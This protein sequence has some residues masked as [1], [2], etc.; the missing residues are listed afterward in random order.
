MQKDEAFNPSKAWIEYINRALGVWVGLLSLALCIHAARHTRKEHGRAFVYLLLSLFLIV[1]QG[2]LGAVVVITHLLPVLV[3]L[4]M[5]LPFLILTT[6]LSA[7]YAL[8]ERPPT[9]PLPLHKRFQ[10]HFTLTFWVA[11]CAF[12]FQVLA[13]TQLREK[14]DVLLLTGLERASVPKH[15]GSLL[16]AH[17]LLGCLSLALYI[18]LVCSCRKYHVRGAL[19]RYILLTASIYFLQV[20]LGASLYHFALPPIFQPLHLLLPFFL[21]TF[22]LLLYKTFCHRMATR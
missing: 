20:L 17:G 16:H 9:P 13:G 5:L 8:A 12:F 6:L 4:H 15:L 2:L 7:T 14:V 1:V 11:L 19:C 22:H 3:T 21:M 10:T 18:F